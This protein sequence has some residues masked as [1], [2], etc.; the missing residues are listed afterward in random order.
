M[1][2]LWIRIRD[3]VLL[4]V[5]LIASVLVLVN[6]NDPVTRSLRVASLKTTAQVESRLSWIAY[7][8]N[9]LRENNSLRQTNIDLSSRLARLRQARLENDRLRGMLALRDTIGLPTLAT[10]IIDK[11][12]TRQKNTLTIDVGAADG[13]VEGMPLINEHGILGK[14]ILT[15]ERHALVQS[16]LNTD[17][18]VPAQVLPIEAFGIVRWDGIDASRLVLDHMV[19]TTPIEPGMEVVTSSSMFFPEGFAIGR[20]DSTSPR[21]GQNEI[22]VFLTPAAPIGEAEHAFVLLVE[23][24]PERVLLEE[25]AVRL[26]T[27]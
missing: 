14:V 4:G 23:P 20:V 27:E 16:Y 10:R 26:Q 25:A 6:R 17:F 22:D 13:V 21:S 7:Y 1:R 24:D 11:D 5:L 3:Y 12:I 19:K 18:R 15:A 2:Q 9:A 8:L